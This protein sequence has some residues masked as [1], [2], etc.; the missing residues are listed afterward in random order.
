MNLKRSSAMKQILDLEKSWTIEPA[1]AQVTFSIRQV[2]IAHIRG[3]FTRFDANIVTLG[4]DF[5]SADVDFVI[6]ATSIE[7]GDF[8]RDAL[9]MGEDF[10]D[11]K[12]FPQIHF[13]SHSISSLKED[14]KR[15]LS[16]ELTM[17]GH[18]Q[19]IGFQLQLGAVNT[20]SE[21]VEQVSLHLSGALDRSN[22]GLV[23]KTEEIDKGFL[24]SR[25]M[26]IDCRIS[27]TSTKNDPNIMTLLQSEFR[28]LKN[29]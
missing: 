19:T 17:K 21:G 12:Q 18:Q 8:R 13:T 16:G 20:V 23:W 11:V 15:E 14:G 28:E 4:N 3:K 10:L 7:T 5:K 27:L 24:V 25:T 29:K 6:D 9:I 1:S 22:W 2:F 26:H